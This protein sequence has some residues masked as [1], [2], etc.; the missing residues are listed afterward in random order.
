MGYKI[1]KETMF[2]ILEPEVN[3]LMREGYKPLGG[4]AVEVDGVG[5][6][7]NRQTVTYYQAMTKETE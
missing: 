5:K 4:L 2:S 1:V 6:F 3:R 7:G